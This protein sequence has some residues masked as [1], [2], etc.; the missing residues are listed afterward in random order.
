MTERLTHTGAGEPGT[1][2]V[3]LG[4]E[5]SSLL[6][7]S[8]LHSARG[9]GGGWGGHLSGAGGHPVSGARLGTDTGLDRMA[10]PR[11]SPASCLLVPVRAILPKS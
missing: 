9:R 6:H 3:D 4:L 10:S 8:G 11:S 2:E 5:Y 7:V 1:N